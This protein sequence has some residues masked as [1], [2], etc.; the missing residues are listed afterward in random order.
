MVRAAACWLLVKIALS[1]PDGAKFFVITVYRFSPT[2]IDASANLAVALYPAIDSE[3]MR[4][5][6]S[7][8]KPVTIH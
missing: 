5:L 6:R 2:S 7:G 3:E 8:E 4:A 1:L